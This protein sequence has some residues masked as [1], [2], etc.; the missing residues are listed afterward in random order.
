MSKLL[1]IVVTPS[2]IELGKRCHRRHVLSDL[3]H[4]RR[5]RSPSL[6]FGSVKHAGASCWWR[7]NSRT[8]ALGVYGKEWDQRLAPLATDLTREL[9]ISVANDYMDKA[10]IA[11]PFSD[12][13]EWQIV[14]LE[15]RL[16]I[17]LAGSDGARLSFQTDRVV[18]CEAT[19]HLVIVDTKTAARIDARW[20]KQWETSLQMKLYKACVSQAYDFDPAVIDV[21]IEGVVKDVPSRIEYVICPQWS[22]KLLAEAV[23]QAKQLAKQD[24]LFVESVLDSTDHAEEIAVNGTSVNYMDCF[25][26]GVECPF[27]TLCTDDPDRRAFRLK[28]EFEKIPE[29]ELEY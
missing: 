26:Y 5:T 15:D 7:T 18:W 9:T 25:S 19:E 11:G 21:V 24:R 12:E 2:R 8:K 10:K 16:E 22:P 20:R 23:L 4:Y 6:E 3:L 29:S 1:P 28:D 27:R 17:P 13:G 14:S